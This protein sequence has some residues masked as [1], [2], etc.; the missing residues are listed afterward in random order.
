MQLNGTRYL[1]AFT[2]LLAAIGLALPAL[3]VLARPASASSSLRSITI[4][5][6]EFSFRSPDSVPAGWTRITIRNIG[7]EDHQA[8]VARLNPGVTFDQPRAA[9]AKG[10]P[11]AVVALVTPV[12]GPNAVGPG[13]SATTIDNLTPGSTRSSAS[14]SRRTEPN[15]TPRGW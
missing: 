12:G 2:S 9:A 3:G 5:T 11:S 1:S 8:Q 14:C 15:T 10:D 4:Q 7:G 13:Q 6:T